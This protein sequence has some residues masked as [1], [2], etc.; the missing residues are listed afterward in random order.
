[1]IYVIYD[2]IKKQYND[3][4]FGESWNEDLNQSAILGQK[5]MLF[6]K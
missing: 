3:I 6:P 2:P 1:M 5:R 4:S